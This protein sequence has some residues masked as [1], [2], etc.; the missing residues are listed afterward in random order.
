MEQGPEGAVWSDSAVDPPGRTGVNYPS[1]DTAY[2]AV[3]HGYLDVGRG[4]RQ[5]E[6]VAVCLL[7]TVGMGPVRVLSDTHLLSDVIGGYL[8]GG[9]WL[10]FVMLWTGHRTSLTR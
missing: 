10:I 3:V 6:L 8:L 1:G 5:P 2:V 9:A 4:H 7:L